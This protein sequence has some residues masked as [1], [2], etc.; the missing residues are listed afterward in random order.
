MLQNPY[1]IFAWNSHR[2]W[3]TMLQ[4]PYVIYENQLGTIIPNM[5]G[6]CFAS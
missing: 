1:V 3:Q 5:Q 6:L 2:I 4:N